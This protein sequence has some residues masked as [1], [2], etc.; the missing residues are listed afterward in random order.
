[1]LRHVDCESCQPC[2]PETDGCSDQYRVGGSSHGSSELFPHH[3]LMAA[4]QV[5]EPGSRH[6]LVKS[7]NG[8]NTI[9]T[10]DFA[11]S[12][13]QR[14]PPDGDFSRTC[15][16]CRQFSVSAVSQYLSIL[17][18]LCLCVSVSLYP[19][20]RHLAQTAKKKRARGRQAIRFPF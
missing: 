6:E 18:S 14:P 2:L 3:G 19:L 17:V 11:Y 8:A 16:R 5:Q 20:G 15:L 12:Q 7:N 10:V 13:Y 9:F 4:H 1:M